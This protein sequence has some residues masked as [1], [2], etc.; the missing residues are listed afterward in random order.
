MADVSQADEGLAFPRKS[1]LLTQAGYGA[2]FKKNRRYA[3]LYWTVLVHRAGTGSN[4]KLGL[5]IAKKRARR[6]VDRNRIKRIAREAFR[7][8]QAALQDNHLV[9]MNRE[10]AAQ[11]DSNQLRRSLDKLLNKIT[12]PRAS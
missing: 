1:R 8:R 2:V 6:A 10:Q 3:D 9:I 11:T 4:A 5:A 12:D 7:H